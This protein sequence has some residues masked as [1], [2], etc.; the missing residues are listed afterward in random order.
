[1]KFKT[2]P[3]TTTSI[4]S[5]LFSI[6]LSPDSL[7]S[8]KAPSSSPRLAHVA[9]LLPQYLT[10]SGRNQSVDTGR[11]GTGFC[12]S[13]FVPFGS[14]DKKNEIGKSNHGNQSFPWQRTCEIICKDRA[15]IDFVE[16][17]SARVC[18]ANHLKLLGFTKGQWGIP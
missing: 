13:H 7:D 17:L 12:L 6:T 18:R 5:Y 16:L 1:M 10:G 11:S 4:P 14:S 15:S 3:I 9:F 2:L 8:S